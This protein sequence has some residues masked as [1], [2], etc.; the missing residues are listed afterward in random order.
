[1]V[2]GRRIFANTIK[3]VLMG[4]SSNFGNMFS[5]AA[6][7]AFLP[8]LPMLPSQILLNNLLYDVGQMT[9]P[10]DR[11]D[12][13]QLARP[14]HWDIGFVRRFMMFFGPISSI[15]DFLTFAVMLN[16]FDAGAELFRSG[17]FVE[18]LATQSLVIFIIRT[19]RVP[20]WRSRPSG[21]LIA[22]SL[23][24]ATVGAVLPFTPLGDTLG[25][26]PLPAGFFAVLV[27]MIVT[28]LGVAELGKR[29]FYRYLGGPVTLRH[30]ARDR[31]T[32]RRAARFTHLGR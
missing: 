18:S 17:W 10:S 16:V 20:F 2:E 31:R 27:V 22:A 8:F 28:Y 24:V 3:Y 29:E 26:T 12:E 30:A 1:V 21:L 32:R 15:F 9:I 25:F 19:R 4:T 7:S 5:A 11:V 13:E 23:S 6:A 14:A